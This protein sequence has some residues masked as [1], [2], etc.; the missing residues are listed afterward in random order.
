MSNNGTFI[1]E[2]GI[3]QTLTDNAANSERAMAVLD[4]AL[5]KNGLEPADVAVLLNT[6]TPEVNERLFASAGR[7]KHEIYGR[8]LVLFAPL[9][10]ANYCTNNCLYCGFRR[11]NTGMQ[12]RV[13]SMAEIA[14]ETLRLE[15]QG[16]KRLMV[17]TGEDAQ[18]SG[19]D[20]CLEA[21]TTIY[22]THTPDGKGAIRRIN[23]EIAPLTVDEFRRL[24]QADIGTYV[25][26]Q[27]TYHP[28]TYARMHPDGPKSDSRWRLYAMDRAQ[29]AGLDD[30]GIGALFGLY[31][32]RFE[33][34]ALLEHARHLEQTF[35][36]GPHTISVP[37]L[38]PA[39]NAPAATN[40]PHPVTDHDFRRL[41]AILRLAVPYTGIILTTRE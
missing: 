26:F 8:R 5:E 16:H 2:A 20:Y 30:V 1:D 21:I 10:I 39:L 6:D 19:L 9:Y 38:E 18:Q 32:Y 31:D 40:V 3:H 15:Q 23:L 4:R 29:E 17:L 24:K 13:L 11:E 35:G 41:I 36:V 33:A 25:L 34:L 14:E 7:V 28:A 37:R 22:N 27:E 12:R